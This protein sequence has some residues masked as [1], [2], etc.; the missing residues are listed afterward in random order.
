MSA[1]FFGM[2]WVHG[3]PKRSF[4]G[5]QWFASSPWKTAA[6]ESKGHH[7]DAQA[8]GQGAVL[9]GPP[10]PAPRAHFTGVTEC[11]PFP[12]RASGLCIV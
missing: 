5:F 11:V 6:S 9:R 1:V 7:V 8:S 12:L 2:K 3:W 4:L 10:G